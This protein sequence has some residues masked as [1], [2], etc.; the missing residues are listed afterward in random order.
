MNRTLLSAL[1]RLDFLEQH[2]TELT[3]GSAEH[4]SALEEFNEVSSW[5]QK[6]Q[7]RWPSETP[8]ETD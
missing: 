7:E 5:L 2:I 6:Q 4:E 8:T 1:T 3:T